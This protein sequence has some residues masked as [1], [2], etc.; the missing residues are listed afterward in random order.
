MNRFIIGDLVTHIS[1]GNGKII[2]FSED[3]SS[4]IVRFDHEVK[5]WGDIL[6][7]STLCLK[8]QEEK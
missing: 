4:I 2:E 3:P 6:E 7:V 8:Y 1:H 5:G